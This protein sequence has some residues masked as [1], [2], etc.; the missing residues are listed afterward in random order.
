VPPA[1]AAPV[2]AVMDVVMVFM[3]HKV[4]TALLL[5]TVMVEAV[6]KVHQEMRWCPALRALLSSDIQL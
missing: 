5:V 4:H 1:P 2:L 3:P 6:V